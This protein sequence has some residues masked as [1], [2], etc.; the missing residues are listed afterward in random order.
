VK[1]DPASHV[2]FDELSTAVLLFDPGLRLVEMNSA[3]ESLLS[4]SRRQAQGASVDDLLPEYPRFGVAVRRALFRRTQFT[5]RNV[6][7][8]TGTGNFVVVDCT[9][10]P[11]SEDGS[12]VGLLVELSNVDRHHQ[13]VRE[14]NMIAQSN[15]TKALVR[16]MAHEIKN[17][18]GG[19]RGAAQL[20]EGE[21]P[22]QS[23]KDY[24]RIIIGEVDRLH[25]LIDQLLA[26][27]RE[28]VREAANIHRILEH[29]RE[30][31]QA[32]A[33]AP[34]EIEVDYDPS[35]PSLSCDRDQLI[36]AFLNVVKN[37][38]QAAAPGGSILIRTRA[39][40]Q[41]SIGTQT[42]KLAIRIDVI[43]DGPGVP[44]ELKESIF[45][46]MVSGRA[47][48]TGLGL[49]IAQTLIQGHAGRIE[50]D[51]KPGWTSFTVW[52]PISQDSLRLGVS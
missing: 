3:A 7:M 21:L 42:H 49:A 40:R 17:P 39:H 25:K 52:L 46:P 32:E 28:T 24:T 27:P 31:V 48:G 1:R 11:V 20:L 34:L 15:V 30:L 6:Q 47:D 41:L 13:I 43:D 50:F 51:S 18:L 10:T 35:L 12:L 4:V 29:V 23:L 16:G 36:Q 8:K 26:P 33:P 37:A 2:L 44:E 22:D 45:F 5:E 14:E 9:V 19:I 38:A